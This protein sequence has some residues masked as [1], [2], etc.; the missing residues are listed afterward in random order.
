MLIIKSNQNTYYK[1]K[2]AHMWAFTKDFLNTNNMQD[3][4][5]STKP[6]LSKFIIFIL[7]TSTALLPPF[8]SKYKSYFVILLKI[9]YRTKE[10]YYTNAI[11]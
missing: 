7:I 3:I 9:F 10:N 2:K 11:T 5:Y 1:A 4:V 8:T 6:L